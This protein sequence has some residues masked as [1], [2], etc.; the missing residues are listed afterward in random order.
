VIW[1]SALLHI[2]SI[3]TLAAAP[4]TW[5]WVV[6]A[7]V[8]NHLCLGA[9][10]MW[11][12]SRLLGPN[13]VRLPDASV[14]RGEVALTFDDGPSPVVTPQVLDLLDRYRAKASFFCIGE[15]AAAHP[16]IVREITRRGHSI[17]NHSCRHS[18]AFACYGPTAQRRDIETTQEIICS[19]TGRR[20]Q[21]FRAPFG[22]RNP[23]LAP[24]LA[25]VGLDY[26]SWTWRGR[27]ATTADPQKVLRRLTGR[28]A[29]GDVLL[30]HDGAS[31]TTLSGQPVVLTV[32]PLLLH[33]IAARGLKAVTLP[34]AMGI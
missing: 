23:F 24:V 2:A 26:V 25:R 33:L 32:L 9:I 10:G 1:C 7:L 6:G 27:D 30:L 31:A 18:A 28:L 19:I 5:P 3:L 4:R 14:Q 12:K 34:A 21:F 16:D 11:P 15:K 17:E 20:P 13:L 8:S 29:A 22:L